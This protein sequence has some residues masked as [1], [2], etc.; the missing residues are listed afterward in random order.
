MK[1]IITLTVLAIFTPLSAY[2]FNGVSGI[3][4]DMTQQEVEKKGFVCK[5]EE[6][7]PKIKIKCQHIDMTG[8]AF[9]FTLGQYT[10]G[11]GLTGKVELI[12]ARFNGKISVV[13]RSLI[14]ARMADFF[15]L[16]VKDKA[17]SGDSVT[18]NVWRAKND[19]TAL[20]IFRRGIDT[21]VK[22]A[23]ILTFWSP[24]ITAYQS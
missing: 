24:T 21:Y 5:D 15:P 4:F 11:I 16:E 20:L 8:E 22:P 19:V 2:A 1:Y 18:Q 17:F 13:D 23:L 3:T 12:T 14:K 6:V 10:L 7:H 9:G